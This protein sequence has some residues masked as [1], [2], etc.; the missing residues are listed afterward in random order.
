V[1]SEG[2]PVVVV[3]AGPFGIALSAHAHAR[4]IPHTLLG[5][6]ME[7][8]KNHMPEGMFL[9]SACDWHLDVDG[10]HTIDAFLASR[11]LRCADILPMSRSLYLDYLAWF[12]SQTHVTAQPSRVRALDHDGQHFDLHLEDG[13]IIRAQ[14]VVVALGFGYFKHLPDEL[15]S[16]L[17]ADSYSH[18]TDLTDFQKLRGKRVLVV[19]GRMAAFEWS[20]LL[21]EAGA[22]AVDIAYRHDTPAF[23]E[24]DWSWIPDILAQ[25]KAD[26]AWYRSRSAEEKDAIQRHMFKEGRLQLEPWLLPRIEEASLHP[27]TRI[28]ACS[29]S[30]EITLDDG[31]IVDVDHIILATG[32]KPD[33]ARVPF[34]RDGNIRDDLQ[35]ADGFP[36]LDTAF[37]SSV[38]GLYFT[39]TLAARDFGPYF[40]FTVSANF[41]AARIIQH[42][43]EHAGRAAQRSV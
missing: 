1:K 41:S 29:D 4:G 27:G 20:A 40:G 26:P 15:T 7:F 16:L 2:R 12:Q 22:A 43:E 14:R 33:V 10:V 18:S 23:T 30:L 24:S 8:W 42:V 19:G 6:P 35:T 3:G 37:Q 34:I 39:S 25:M 38:P 11:G 17:P 36:V 5:E 28:L 21:L 32:Y 31:T 13:E 9:R